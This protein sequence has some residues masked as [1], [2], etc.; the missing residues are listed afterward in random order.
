MLYMMLPLDRHF[1]SGFGAVADSFRDAADALEN[2][3]ENTP[4]LNDHLPI[5]YL[6]RHAI[7]LYLKSAII[8][9]HRKL[10]I[11]YGDTPASGEP[12]V[13]DG[14]KWKPM[15][16]VHGLQPLYRH[17]CFLFED[18]AEYLSTHTNTD[19]SFPA[20]LGQWISD[21]EETDSSSTFFR[22]PVTKDKAKDKEKSAIREDDY[23]AMLSKVKQNQRPVKA[24]LMVGQDQNVIEAFSLDDTRSKE[25]IGTLKQVAELF[26]N[27]HAV[28]VGELTGGA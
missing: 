19:W 10:N 27:C 4:T 11:P 7:E 5:S 28:M 16:N 23:G 25:I 15:F 22:Y 18:H 8:I 9:F 1:D 2:T 12:K 17:F 14:A 21:I 13:L 26:S 24:F 20:E 3:R 6:Y